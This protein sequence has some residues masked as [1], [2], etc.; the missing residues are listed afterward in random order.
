[1]RRTRVMPSLPIGSIRLPRVH[2]AEA[3]HGLKRQPTFLV[4][5]RDPG[6]TAAT[7]LRPTRGTAYRSAP[8]AMI[9]IE[10]PATS[11]HL[12][13]LARGAAHFRDGLDGWICR[14][15]DIPGSRGLECNCE[16]THP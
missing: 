15:S 7:L 14:P 3:R 2:G 8:C 9:V 10:P 5:H 6:R 16:I 13:P 1:M 4:R 12:T 11:T